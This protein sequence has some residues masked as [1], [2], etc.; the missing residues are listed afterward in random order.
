MQSL[1]EREREGGRDGEGGGGGDGEGG[2]ERG[3]EIRRVRKSR[4]GREGGGMESGVMAHRV[5]GNL[6]EA[7]NVLWR[8]ET[9]RSLLSSLGERERERER[10]VS[11]MRVTKE[12]LLSS[13][14]LS[15]EWLC[16]SAVQNYII[17]TSFLHTPSRLPSA[18]SPL[19]FHLVPPFPWLLP[20]LLV[21]FHSE[22]HN[23]QPHEASGWP[24]LEREMER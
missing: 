10:L 11:D 13:S 19:S 17:I 1:V 14:Q 8:H 2:G 15:V 18:E 16:P 23:Y 9:F 24:G 22:W 7:T 21:H 6:F 4:R 5:R 20:G 3:R 12:N